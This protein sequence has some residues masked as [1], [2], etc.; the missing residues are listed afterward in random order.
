M[1]NHSDPRATAYL[2]KEDALEATEAD[3]DFT[4]WNSFWPL[5]S[6]QIWAMVP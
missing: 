6:E 1:S 4:R 5:G 2:W 3:S